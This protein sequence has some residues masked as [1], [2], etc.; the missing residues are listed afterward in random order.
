MNDFKPVENG[1]VTLVGEI[2]GQYHAEKI[3]VPEVD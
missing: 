3:F 2:D 1:S